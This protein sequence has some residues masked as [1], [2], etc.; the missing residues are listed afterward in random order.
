V[1]DIA[2][3]LRAALAERYEVQDELGRGGMSLVF[4]ARDR[5]H[6]RLVAIKVLRPE[7]AAAIGATRFLREIE[8]AA[9]LQHP[10]ILPLYD[11]G[12]AA[13]IL[14]YVMPFVEGDSLRARL[15]RSGPLP[16]ADALAIARDVASALAYAHHHGV[17]HRDV[18]PENV[19]LAG[20]RATVTDFGI[21][22]AVAAA[23]DDRLTTSGLVLGTPAYMSPEQAAG[24]PALDERSDVY[25]LGVMLYEMLT[26]APPFGGPNVQAVVA[27]HLSDP[28]PSLRA[29]RPGIS[30]GL[31]RTVQ[32]ALA[33]RPADRFASAAAFERALTHPDG[34]APAK[35]RRRTVRWAIA[36]AGVAVLAWLVW[37][38]L[39]RPPR[40]AS[41]T[42]IA[43]LPFDNLSPDPQEAYF[44]AGI[45]EE[46]VTT[47]G[48][49]PGVR[50]APPTSAGELKRRAADAREIGRRL[51][52][53]Y[54]LTG[55]VRAAGDSLRVSARLVSTTNGFQIW[56]DEYRG[57]RRDAFAVQ[58][59]ISAAIVQSLR[60]RLTDSAATPVRHN[61]TDPATYEL[62][63]KG[64]YFWNQRDREGLAHAVEYFSEAV[65]SDSLFAP[66]W[67]GLGDA[68]SMIAVFGYQAPAVVFPRARTAI[69]RALA[70]DPSLAEG[71]TSLAI[72]A[73]FY[74]W[75]WATARR[76]LDQ[77][78]GLDSSYGPA[79]L[80]RAWYFVAVDSVPAALTELQAAQV[81]DPLSLII[82]T[83]VATMLNYLGRSSEAI[84]QARRVIELDS[85]YL[86][87]QV[88]VVLDLAW[89]GQC[90]SSVD[91]ARALRV[92]RD[93]DNVLGTRAL[94]YA[95]CGRRAEASHLVAWFEAERR[96]RY[97]SPYMIAPVYAALGDA[98]QA[99][100]W[101]DTAYADHT[102]Y[103]LQ[104]RQDPDYRRFRDDARFQRLLLR[105]R[106]S[107]DPERA[108][109]TR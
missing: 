66:A 92:A 84:A 104:L 33:K 43:V 50:V 3:Q 60:L 12:E 29:A 1:I 21:A 32:H 105:L 42:A 53:G 83:R 90:Q 14:Y 6:D 69:T 19:L 59:R 80:F 15:D 55:G 82:G 39:L 22:R 61:R 52:V 67:S 37:P 79:H 77:A 4:L 10:H 65:A 109:G 71:H 76:E 64:R 5:K 89:S 30:A 108:G 106:L 81:H 13:D 87:A 28:V 68:Y 27:G 54:V 47:L 88:E 49:V 18:K 41:A 86:Q 62:Y 63:L 8:T 97:V 25:S 75:D 35:L 45:A 93:S 24:D 17:V 103:L 7:L 2:T 78:V 99:F 36:A 51:G 56:A 91:A 101:L 96:R 34:T 26:G 31:E 11:S 44:G 95:V 98:P 94:A 102:W 48:R 70:L 74:D 57:D 58:E 107:A 85:S 9:R 73:L 20:G 40:D 72:V 100:A 16:V 46:L 38:R 23:A